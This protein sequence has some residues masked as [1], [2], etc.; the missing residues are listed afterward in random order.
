MWDIVGNFPNLVKIHS[1]RSRAA[2]ENGER[3]NWNT[4]AV[5][6][7]RLKL[8]EIKRDRPFV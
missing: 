5:C 6:E 1:T 2:R 7:G 4:S 8:S 3:E